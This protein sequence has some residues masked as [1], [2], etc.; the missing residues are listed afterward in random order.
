MRSVR[1]QAMVMQLLG[2]VLYA[3]RLRLRGMMIGKG[4][5]CTEAGPCLPGWRIYT[6]EHL[7]QH[8]L[9]PQP[10]KSRTDLECF[11]SITWVLRNSTPGL[12]IIAFGI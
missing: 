4:F 3:D 11:A 10:T 9:V 2:N 6:V 1:I 7:Y 8:A 5:A 12:L